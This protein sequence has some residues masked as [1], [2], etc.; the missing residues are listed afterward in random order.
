MDIFVPLLRVRLLTFKNSRS[1]KNWAQFLIFLAF[2]ALVIV[3]IYFGT[4]A[5]LDKLDTLNASQKFGTVMELASRWIAVGDLIKQRLLSMVILAISFMLFFSQVLSIISHLYLSHD[6]ELLFASP[7]SDH[8]IFKT[9]FLEATFAST[10]MSFLFFL[11]VL[12]AYLKNASATLGSF[13]PFLF[14]LI[15]FVL[16]PACLGTLFAMLLA[17]YFPIS[18]SRRIFQF[19]SVLFFTLL[20][21]L[22]RMLQPEKLFS[23][24]DFSQ[25]QQFIENLQLPFFQY[26][27]STWLADVARYLLAGDPSG[28]LKPGLLLFATAMIFLWITNA[29]AK[30]IY[31]PSWCRSR[32][33]R[34]PSVLPTSSSKAIPFF[35]QFR[36]SLRALYT[37]DSLVFAR[38]PELWSQ[39]F[40]IFAMVGLY[41]YNI[42]LLHLDKVSIFSHVLSKFISFINTT[43]VGFIMI[44]ISMRFLFPAISLEGPSFWILKSS[45]FP[46]EKLIWFKYIYHVPLLLIMGNLM[47]ILANWILAVPWYLYLL[48]GFNITA[49]TLSSS[50]LA[51]VFGA[52]YPNF[53]AENVNRIFMSFGGTFYM[54]VSLGLMFFYL[55]SQIPLGFLIYKQYIR[56]QVIPDWHFALGGLSLIMG[57][58]IILGATVYLY[59]RGV[60]TLCEVEDAND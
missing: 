9:R 10:W 51:I 23:I 30:K 43:F 34:A 7:L 59:Y 3:S 38:N 39:V 35:R 40:L 4:V 15:P 32:E 47:S 19:L 37:K 26:I 2:S 58:L 49:L 21:L 11:P 27:P 56:H 44:S 50:L 1:R 17:H 28:G 8:S 52:L 25:I 18:Q 57:L 36:P 12:M 6:T 20:L 45:P 42:H 41:L 55:G 31:Y 46:M 33:L 54:M 48:N 22:I 60:K 53:K 14:A 5:L 16:I 29:V 24:Q 13:I